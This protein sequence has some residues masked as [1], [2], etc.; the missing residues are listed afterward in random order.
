MRLY[1]KGY[2][3]G[4]VDEEATVANCG[5]N[6]TSGRGVFTYQISTLQDAIDPNQIVFH[7]NMSI[8]ISQTTESHDSLLSIHFPLD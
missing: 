8:E 1:G 2:S 7:I 6:I 5:V 3:H 4:S